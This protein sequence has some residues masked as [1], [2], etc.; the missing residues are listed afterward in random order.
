MIT[1]YQID[2]EPEQI[3]SEN[4]FL[5]REGNHTITYKLFDKN[6]V[7]K[8]QKKE[9]VLLLTLKN[10]IRKLSLTFMNKI[11]TFPF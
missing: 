5:L 11:R 3:L 7:L 6:G 10:S 2:D 9:K 1:V 8:D 4:S